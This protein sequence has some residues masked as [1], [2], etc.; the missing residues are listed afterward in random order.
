M[1]FLS[2]SWLWPLIFLINVCEGQDAER[3]DKIAQ[4]YAGE[5]QFMGCVL[6]AR[7][8]E[9]LLNKGYGLANAEWNIPNEPQTRFRIASL[10]K[11]FT[12]VAI[13]L[14]E[15]RG[16]LKVSDSIGQY[17][18]NAPLQWQ[19]ITLFQLLTHTSGVPDFTDDPTVRCKT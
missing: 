9:V 1:R 13:L 5:H 4:Y 8:D 18:E 11:Q 15:E 17:L 2:R 10:T 19:N 7:G 6:V 16:K 12:A 14:L 3:I